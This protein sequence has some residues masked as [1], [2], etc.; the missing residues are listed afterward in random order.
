MIVKMTRLDVYA[1]R[2]ELE[3]LIRGLLRKKCVQIDDPELR[4]DYSQL[5]TK[6]SRLPDDSV[7]FESE[8]AKTEAAI[9]TLSP[10]IK[11]G[12]LFSKKYESDFS[13]LEDESNIEKALGI[14]S[15]VEAAQKKLSDLR[16]EKN[17]VSN[18]ISSVS[19]WV[20]CDVPLDFTESE[21]VRVLHAILP[22]ESDF[23]AF[24]EKF[25]QE[26]PQS[27]I[28]KISEDSYSKYL[29]IVFSKS[30]ESAAD[31]ILK[32][33]SAVKASF[34]GFSGLASEVFA[35]LGIDSDRLDSELETAESEFKA[36]AEKSETLKIGYDC[37]KLK[38]ELAKARLKT[39]STDSSFVFSGWVPEDKQKKISDFLDGF[40]CYYEFRAP[41]P[42][43]TAPVLMKNGPWAEP[44]ESITEMYGLPSPSGV[45][46]DFLMAPFFFTFFGMML[47]DAGYGLILIVASL[48]A[49]KKMQLKESAKKF[50][51]LIFYCGISTVIWG[52]IYG[53]WFGNLIPSVASTF[54]GKTVTVPALIDPLTEPVKILVIS[55]IFGA[56]HLFCGMGIKFYMLCKAGHFWDALFDIGSW[57]LILLGLGA[58]VLGGI[59]ASI[60]KIAAIVGA[61]TLILTQGRHEKKFFKKIT[62]GLLSLYDIT[63]YTSDLLSYSRILALGMATGVI[64]TVVN[65]IATLFGSG[66]V[67]AILFIVIFVLGHLLNLAINALGSYVHSSRLQYVEFFGKFYEGGGKPFSPLKPDTKY[68]FFINKEDN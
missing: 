14:V 56:V 68:T 61:A 2:S 65:T 63:S 12:G 4:S 26:I 24:S 32:D 5:M 45:D 16:S 38:Y 36:L 18:S 55:L 28:F 15:E 29:L 40:D 46:P 51:K 10:F 20:S 33:F 62:K 19:P 43:E 31:D 17:R 13:V 52:A 50:M 8:L 66:I 22:S 34:S 9:K 3:K 54:F 49:M 57:Y 64:A 47:S 41:A 48:F 42:D 30:S 25:E 1:I 35:Q 58:L 27:V 21:T 37:I 39:L 6:V 23:T 53:G 7:A 44:F 60:G 11:K 67:S 59:A